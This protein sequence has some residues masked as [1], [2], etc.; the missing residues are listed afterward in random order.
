M[1]AA[2]LLGGG[3]AALIG[4]LTISRGWLRSRE[5]THYLLNNL[6]TYAWF[7][8]LGGLFFYATARAA[9]AGPHAVHDH[10]RPRPSAGRR[11]EVERARCAAVGR[12]FASLRPACWTVVQARADAAD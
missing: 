12:R 1:L 4:V 5:D 10:L 8:L 11:D 6:A 3:S 2:V 9:H 7:P